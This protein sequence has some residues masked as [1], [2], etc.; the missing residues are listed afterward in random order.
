MNTHFTNKET[1]PQKGPEMW[2]KLPIK[3]GSWFCS[4]ACLGASESPALLSEA[5]RYPVSP[6]GW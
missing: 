2:Y 4:Q 1:E 5:A 6:K 3:R